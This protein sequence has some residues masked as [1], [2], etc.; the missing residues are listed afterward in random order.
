MSDPNSNPRVIPTDR[1]EFSTVNSSS[2]RGL[3]LGQSQA[4][5]FLVN[6]LSNRA[7][8]L[9]NQQN[10][11]DPYSSNPRAIPVERTDFSAGNSSTRSAPVVDKTVFDYDHGQTGEALFE[12]RKPK[13]ESLQASDEKAKA[14]A[15]ELEDERRMKQ[16]EESSDE[17]EILIIRKGRNQS[18]QDMRVHMAESR[19][20]RSKTHR[21]TEGIRS[22]EQDDISEFNMYGF[23]K[24]MINPINPASLQQRPQAP[25]VT[26]V[27][28]QPSVLLPQQNPATLLQAQG[29][30]QSQVPLH[31]MNMNPQLFNPFLNTLG[32]LSGMG[33]MGFPQVPASG[34]NLLHLPNPSIVA[35]NMTTGFRFPNPTVNHGI[36]APK[37]VIVP[38][39]KQDTD[40]QTQEEIMMARIK[41]KAAESFSHRGQNLRAPGF[42][43]NSENLSYAQ[44]TGDSSISHEQSSSTLP[45]M[46]PP[47]QVLDPRLKPRQAR[48]FAPRDFRRTDNDV[49][50]E[51]RRRYVPNDDN[52][53]PPTERPN[54]DYRNSRPS[55][56]ERVNE[57]RR[58][59]P[60]WERRYSGSRKNDDRRHTTPGDYHDSRNER[61]SRSLGDNDERRDDKHE[62]TRDGGSAEDRVERSFI[63][64]PGIDKSRGRRDS[65]DHCN[66][67]RVRRGAGGLEVEENVER[68]SRDFTMSDKRE[69]VSRSNLSKL[70][71]SVDKTERR[72]PDA[73]DHGVSSTK[74]PSLAARIKAVSEQLNRAPIQQQ[75]PS[76]HSRLEEIRR[77][78]EVLHPI[79]SNSKVKALVESTV[80]DEKEVVTEKGTRGRKAQ[81]TSGTKKKSNAVTSGRKKFSCS[82]KAELANGLRRSPRTKT[83]PMKVSVAKKAK[84]KGSPVRS[85]AKAPENGPPTPAVFRIPKLKKSLPVEQ[86][87]TET[88]DRYEELSDSDQELRIDTSSSVRHKATL[89]YHINLFTTSAYNFEPI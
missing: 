32:N 1:N 37:D 28:F 52:R 57:D 4:A 6:T 45:S 73:D 35:N 65:G 46:G 71:E 42:G 11:T 8:F 49:G 21:F 89:L 19:P 83:P 75:A 18:D 36:H 40:R 20:N 63:V 88:K 30:P 81:G 76:H 22:P 87:V 41:A 64:P 47:A 14:L 61:F 70:S 2:S 23:G 82:G 38:P 39:I 7:D 72:A 27:G 51:Q 68:V 48:D 74:F 50:N 9:F 31:L 25:G 62:S 66:D 60:D 10:R 44:S 59:I 67:N 86:T 55:S 78:A 17:E 79:G 29:Q 16:W 26:P 34:T 33:L 56:A 13:V 24:D 43:G 77:E 54:D 85:T 3:P 15:K 53:R 80:A 5:S 84:P 58:H 12:R 69:D